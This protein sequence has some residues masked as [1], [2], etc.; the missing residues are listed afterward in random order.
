MKRVN[1]IMLLVITLTSYATAIFSQNLESMPKLKR[2]SL[3]IAKAEEYVLKYGPGYYRE[4]KTPLIE[5][6][7]ISPKRGTNPP[8]EDAG[9]VIYSVIF[10]YDTVKELL[11]MPYTAKV[12]FWGDKDGVPVFIEFGNGIGIFLES[13]TGQ[14]VQESTSLVQYQQ[15]PL[16]P[17]YDSYDW[18]YEDK[19]K[20]KNIDELRRRGYEYQDGE[21]VN[22]KKDVPPNNEDLLKRKG[23][24]EIDGQWVRVKKQEALNRKK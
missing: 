10:L 19:A 5:R 17:I 20:P 9:R 21:W 4:Y 14:Q 22:P 1:K 12:N 23:F 11:E 6:S 15:S 7:T 16:A 18:E 13:E 24:E 2:D 8:V 3:L